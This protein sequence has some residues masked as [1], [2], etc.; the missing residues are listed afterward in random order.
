MKFTNNCLLLVL[1]KAFDVIGV[2]SYDLCGKEWL[3]Q[4]PT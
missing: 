4:V 1:F 2:L 3:M